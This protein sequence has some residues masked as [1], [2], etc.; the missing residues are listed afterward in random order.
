MPTLAIAVLGSTGRQSRRATSP[1]NENVFYSRAMADYRL[2]IGG[3]RVAGA[4]GTYGIVNPATE[5]IVGE[6]P[7]AS[8]EQAQQ[9]TEAAAAAFPAWS[10][11]K[12]EER[13]ELLNRAADL[14]R[15]RMEDL[16]PLVQA[17]TGATQRV[18]STMQVPTCIERLRRCEGRSNRPRSRYRPRRCRRPRWPPAGSSARPSSANRSVWSQCITPYNF[19]IV[20]MAGKVGPALAMGN[21]VVVKPAPQDPL[22]VL[23]SASCSPRPASG[24]VNRHRQWAR[25]RRR[26]RPRPTSTWCPSPGRRRWASASARSAA[27][28]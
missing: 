13:A 8:V 23:S 17:E 7:E 20:N 21:T 15:D 14:L 11:T 26:S 10:R 19:P 18:A 1:E 28:R 16:I 27:G 22:A 9:A 3:E 4:R 2:L 5:Q 25:P 6:A 12:P 24:V